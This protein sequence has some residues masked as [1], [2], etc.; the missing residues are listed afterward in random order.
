[1]KS[2]KN[3]KITESKRNA[4]LILSVILLLYLA[5]QIQDIRLWFHSVT[6]EGEKYENVQ[7]ISDD[8][9]FVYQ[10]KYKID[11]VGES[12]IDKDYINDLLEDD[13][14]ALIRYSYSSGNKLLQI[15]FTDAQTISGINLSYKEVL[16]RV[17]VSIL[18][19]L[20]QRELM[21]DIKA[22]Q[23]YY[24]PNFG[25]LAMVGVENIIIPLDE[26]EREL[27]ENKGNSIEET[28]TKITLKFY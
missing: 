7:Q 3:G 16:T 25:P 27:Q 12:I 9:N 4:L 19:F 24:Q 11:N 1:M 28:L 17:A 6:S 10:G 26:F 20:F 22:V 5:W 8:L 23:F 13:Q 14:K 21:D 2:K 18:Y 15:S